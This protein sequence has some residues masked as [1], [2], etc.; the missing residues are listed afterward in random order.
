VG[1]SH[2]RAS[3]PDVIA[4]V[5]QGLVAPEKVQT[6]V[7]EWNDAPTALLEASTK[8]VMRRQPLRC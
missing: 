2:P 4:L 6:C 8:V 3:L 1:L 7:A 5:A